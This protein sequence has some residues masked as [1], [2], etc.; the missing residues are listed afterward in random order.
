MYK[1]KKCETCTFGKTI[2]QWDGPVHS[3]ISDYDVK[4]GKIITIF[5]N[6]VQI[7]IFFQ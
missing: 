3:L 7:K 2:L 5:A 6:Y 4:N 1:P